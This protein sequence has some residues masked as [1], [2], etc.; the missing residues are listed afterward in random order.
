MTEMVH[1]YRLRRNILIILPY[2]FLTLQVAYIDEGGLGTGLLFSSMF[3]SG[4]GLL[5]N[6]PL[7]GPG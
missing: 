6:C 2:S 7:S 5:D 3:S 4:C 1:V